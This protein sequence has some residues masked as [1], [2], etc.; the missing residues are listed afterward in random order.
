MNR[1][2][3]AGYVVMRRMLEREI[4]PKFVELM[5]KKRRVACLWGHF[6]LKRQ[7]AV[8]YH[9]NEFSISLLLYLI[10]RTLT[11]TPFLPPPPSSHPYM[12]VL[13]ISN[14]S[15][16]NLISLRSNNI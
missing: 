13:K 5:V 12:G 4:K 3:L 11:L 16:Y 2:E 9:P 10:K 15:A 14:I 1:Q 6:D 8:Y 7:A